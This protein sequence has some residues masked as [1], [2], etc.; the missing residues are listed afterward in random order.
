[1]EI[2]K[3]MIENVLG[4]KINKFKL[5]P[6]YQNGECIGL[7]VYVRPEQEVKFINTKITIVKA[8][9]FNTDENQ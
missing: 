2:T 7:S 8:S 4:Y 6:L 9:D 1:M 5:E 3:E